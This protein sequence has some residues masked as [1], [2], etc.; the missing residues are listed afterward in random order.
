[1]GVLPTKRPPRMDAFSILE[2]DRNRHM[3]NWKFGVVSRDRPRGGSDPIEDELMQIRGRSRIKRNI[4][5]RPTD[6][7]LCVVLGICQD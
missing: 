1:M 3:R 5:G 4:D 6:L 7:E 2:I